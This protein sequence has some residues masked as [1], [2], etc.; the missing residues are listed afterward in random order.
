MS[1]TPGPQILKISRL[2]VHPMARIPIL[3][4][5][6]IKRRKFSN[7]EIGTENELMF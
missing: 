3:T 2:Q 6:S 7:L 5:I 4:E 1:F